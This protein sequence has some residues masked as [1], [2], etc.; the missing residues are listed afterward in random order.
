MFFVHCSSLPRL[1]ACPGS[2]Q[3][4]E[5]IETPE[6]DIAIL[7]KVIHAALH[8]WARGDEPDEDKLGDRER[9]IYR[10]FRSEVER[11]EQAHGGYMLRLPELKLNA[12]YAEFILTGRLD[13]VIQP[14]DGTVHLI[15]YKTGYA[16]QIPAKL[17]KQLLGYDVLLS[18]NRPEWKEINAHLFSAGDPPESRFT[19]TCYDKEATKAAESYL[20]DLIHAAIQPDAKRVPGEHCQYCPALSTVRCPETAASI[21]ETRD[22]VI[23]QPVVEML[24][25]PARCREIFDAIKA[26]E[27]YADVFMSV[28]KLAVQKSPEAW[29]DAFALKD[30]ASKRSFTSVEEACNRLIAEGIEPQTIWRAV[31]LSP[32]QTERLLKEQRPMKGKVAQE[33]FDRI[34]NDL[35]ESKQAAPSLVRVK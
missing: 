26:V 34:F 31:N 14:N 20:Y 25:A 15:D 33:Y 12:I 6:S 7:G 11:L 24:P 13:L 5:G 29:K 22:A 32:A 35:I 30:G 8:S 10:F 1:S 18:W 21:L 17:N 4:A 9:M 16:E 3:A 23:K 28:L 27:R 2:L 19:A